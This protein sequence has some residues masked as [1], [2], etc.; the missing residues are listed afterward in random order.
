MT[1]C[2]MCGMAKRKDQP[3]DE[4]CPSANNMRHIWLDPEETRP[5][6]TPRIASISKVKATYA[7]EGICEH[8][9]QDVTRTKTF[10]GANPDEIDAQA[11]R[12]DTGPLLHYHCEGPFWAEHRRVETVKTKG[13]LL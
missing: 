1:S 6:P 10:T 3:P 12:W 2:V 11:E 8:C 13:G 4:L 7:R 9:E 5:A